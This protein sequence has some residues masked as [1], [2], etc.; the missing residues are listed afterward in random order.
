M[1]TFSKPVAFVSLTQPSQRPPTSE[2]HFR[3]FHRRVSNMHSSFSSSLITLTILTFSSSF[4]RASSQSA[5]AATGAAGSC[6]PYGNATLNAD[7]TA[8]SVPRDQWFCSV[9]QQYGFQ[10]FSYPLEDSDCSADSN[11]F[12]SM[13]KDFARM[14][15]DFGATMVRLYYPGCTESIV[16]ENAL[17]AGVANNMAVIPQIWFGFDNDVRILGP[18]R[19]ETYSLMLRRTRSGK[20]HSRPSMLS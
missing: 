6:F 14:K 12:D 2:Y 8:P 7:Y 18:K 4:A 1:A 15:S 3:S 16:F 13:S 17:R 20:L 9:D 11:S 19:P 5:G 10:G